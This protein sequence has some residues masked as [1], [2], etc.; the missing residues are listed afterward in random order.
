MDQLSNVIISETHINSPIT[1]YF[2]APTGRFI[3]GQGN[4]LV[5]N[6]PPSQ[7]LKGRFHL[8]TKN[9]SSLSN[10][11]I[12]CMPLN[13]PVHFAPSSKHPGTR[14]RETPGVLIPARSLQASV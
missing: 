4:A 13:T 12:S 11:K 6:K 3:T 14:C 10:I 7:A 9:Y 1:I 2:Q 5:H 8:N